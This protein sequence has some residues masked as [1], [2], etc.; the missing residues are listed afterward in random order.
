MNQAAVNFDIAISKMPRK[1][2][3]YRSFRAAIEAE[4]LQM[5]VQT[6]N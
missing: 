1:I 5:V 6:I 2:R 4:I 3:V